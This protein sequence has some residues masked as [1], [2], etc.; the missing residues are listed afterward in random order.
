MNR[1]EAIEKLNCLI[2]QD[3]VELAKKF[4][5][6]IWTGTTK[7]KGW[8][9]HTIEKYLG[10]ELNSTQKPD[11]GD[12]ELKIVPLLYDSFGK[13]KV[14]ETMAITMINPSHVIQHDF[15]DSHL[16][17]KLNRLVICSRIFESQSEDH[18]LFHSAAIFDLS[19]NVLFEQVKKDYEE[20]KSCIIT[21]GFNSLS[22]NMGQLVQPRTK[23]PGHGSTSRAF[24]ARIGFV[25]KILKL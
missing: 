19:N 8:A 3:L 5:V 24:Y 17:A 14:K 16:L 20:T 25:E 10:L 18:S 7:N 2:N 23:G 22:G 11:F 21:N 9:G 6:T 1:Q 12:W 13:L 15:E 4:N